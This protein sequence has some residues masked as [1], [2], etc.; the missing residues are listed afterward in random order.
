MTRSARLQTFGQGIQAVN[1]DNEKSINGAGTDRIAE[2]AQRQFVT[3]WA[4]GLG[5]SRVQKHGLA[6]AVA[7]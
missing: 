6:F 7:V 2:E 4:T 3:H 1:K 5:L